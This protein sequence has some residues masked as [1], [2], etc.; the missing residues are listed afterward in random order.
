MGLDSVELL[1][2]IEE[3]FDIEFSDSE[4]EKIYTVGDFYNGVWSKI[5]QKESNKCKSAMLFYKLR[6]FLQERYGIARQ[7]LKLNTDLDTIIPKG[8]RKAEWQSIQQEFEF[9]LPELVLP[10]W[11]NQSLF[12]FGIITVLGG[13][14][15]ALLAINLWGASYNWWF[16]PV[17]GFTLTMLLS[18]IFRPFKTSIKEKDI[19][20]FVETVLTL[21][22]RQISST[23]G[24]NRQEMEKVMSIIIQDRTGVEFSEIKPEASITNDLGLD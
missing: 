7:D 22:Y 20:E 4:A 5:K 24:T 9:K 2:A 10:I 14:I 16:I 8:K 12:Y 21:N 18:Q 1:V 15:I 23:L 6:S 19:K 11:L 3:T 17:C 13:L